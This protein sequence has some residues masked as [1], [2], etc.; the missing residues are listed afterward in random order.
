MF[1]SILTL[2]VL[3]LVSIAKSFAAPCPSLDEVKEEL[4]RTLSRGSTIKDSTVGV[5]RWSLYNAPNP[6]FV[7]SVAEESDVAT[8]VYPPE[9][10]QTHLVLTI[11]R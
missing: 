6:T 11:C 10:E 3:F 9:T 5:R 7:V 2:S 1:T 4:G 8:T